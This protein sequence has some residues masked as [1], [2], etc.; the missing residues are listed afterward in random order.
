MAYL[1][2]GTSKIERAKE[3]LEEVITLKATHNNDQA[4][5]VGLEALKLLGITIKKNPKLWSILKEVNKTKRLFSPRKIR[6]IP[7][8]TSVL[9]T[10]SQLKLAILVELTVPALKVNEALWTIILMRI[11]CISMKKGNSE[12]AA[13]G[14]AGFALIS[15]RY[16]EDDIQAEALY[17]V[18]FE[19]LETYKNPRTSCI[20]K[21]ILAAHVGHM[22]VPWHECIRLLDEGAQEAFE[23]NDLVVGGL[24]LSYGIEMAFASGVPLSD[25]QQRIDIAK[26]H[27][28]EASGRDIQVIIDLYEAFIQCNSRED[29]RN[30]PL[31]DLPDQSDT[32]LHLP[33]HLTQTMLHMTMAYNLGRYEEEA[34]LFMGLIK[35][36]NALK[37]QFI[38]GVFYHYE[39]MLLPRLI[40]EGQS[41]HISK[42]RRR[43]QDLKRLFQYWVKRNPY[44]YG[45]SYKMCEGGIAH[46]SGD[47]SGGEEA[48][49]MAILLAAEEQS[50]YGQGVA[51]IA[52]A[53]HCRHY[54][55]NHMAT[56][57]MKEGADLFRQWHS[58]AICN[59]IL[60]S[61]QLIVDYDQVKDRWQVEEDEMAAETNDLYRLTE[62]I[63]LQVG[64]MTSLLDIIDTELGGGKILIFMDHQGSLEL[65]ASSDKGYSLGADIDRLDQISVKT[66]KHAFRNVEHILINKDEKHALANFD[67]YVMDHGTGCILTL[68]LACA[69]KAIGVLYIER[70]E[71]FD[72]KEVAT[73]HRLVA[74]VGF[75]QCQKSP[76]SIKKD[77]SHLSNE[78][79]QILD[80]LVKG[81][82]IKE[83]SKETGYA[84]NNLLALIRVL[85][86]RLDAMNLYELA[87]NYEISQE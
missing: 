43:L 47:F 18:T 22:F 37:E 60:V 72:E 41:K 65:E 78:D 61:E 21:F 64:T 50:I 3:L 11:A 82:S 26:G 77:L 42:D 49:E 55:R 40:M 31:I 9:S 6:K 69:G 17:R 87:C 63:Q 57:Y 27:N 79:R 70:Q 56:Y 2:N 83:I 16:L 54:G 7:M 53:N 66:I 67:A 85:Y 38:T 84:L 32:A 45:H 23:S 12:S 28:I 29:C 33:V 35:E 30:Y 36:I 75:V 13:V 68:A 20:V 52:L 73:L 34:Q 19:L 14:Y 10:K 81:M 48:Y 71:P 44:L 1:T 8:N 4:I 76:S 74:Y 15:V 39:S 24:C 51:T 62:K 5:T 80:C 58:A 46:V 25:L 86:Q 59:H